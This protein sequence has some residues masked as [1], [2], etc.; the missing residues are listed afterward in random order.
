[1]N[2]ITGHFL[3]K[4]KFFMSIQ[5]VAVIG[6]GTMGNGI[7]QVCATSGYQT[8]LID[9]SPE[10][11]ERAKK[12]IANSVTK[13]H[14]KGKLDDSARNN[15]I[16]GIFTHTELNAA[17]EADLV[18]EAATENKAI[19]FKIFADLDR[20]TRPD[21]ILASNTSSISLTEIAAATQRAKQVVG[22]HFMN[23]VPIMQLVEVIRG[24]ETDQAT[25][26]SVMAFTQSLGKTPV[27]SADFPGFI[28]N[29][30]LCPMLN[31]AIYCV[32]EGVGSPEAIDTVMKLGMNHP[33]GPLALADF[34]GLDVLLS[35][36][37]VLYEGFGDP[38][39]RACPLLRKM[40]AAG[41]LGKK[42]GRGFYIYS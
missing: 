42:S 14:S 31:E 1:M 21:T 3:E 36:M 41:Q 39:Y 16:D 32:M 40:V 34:I 25:L 18:I 24:L 33:M 35:I 30:I 10:A 22:V 17:S 29:R 5:K 12:T 23:P 2:L 4:S 27:E 15:A 6:A 20:L 19:K 7:A 26:E 37:D 13:L 11:L 28:S 9:V 38:K 8:T